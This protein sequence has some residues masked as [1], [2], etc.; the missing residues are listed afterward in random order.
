MTVVCQARHK[1]FNTV[2]TTLKHKTMKIAEYINEDEGM[3]TVVEQ[4]SATQFQV[5][6]IDLDSDNIIP[7]IHILTNLEDAIKEAKKIVN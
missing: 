7:Y 6:T 1:L 3:K 4:I 5:L 2:Q